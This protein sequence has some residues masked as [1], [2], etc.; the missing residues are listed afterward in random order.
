MSVQKSQ[1]EA[2]S[3]SDGWNHAESPFHAGEQQVQERLGVRDKIETFA[4]RAVRDYMPDQ[5]REFYAK[6]PFVLVGTVDDRG[7]PWASLVAKRPGFMTSPDARHLEIAARPL[8][9]DPLNGTLKPGADVGLLGIDPENRRRNR[10]TGRIDTVGPDGFAVAIG[11]AF[12]NC[13]QYIQTRAIEVLPEAKMGAGDPPLSWSDRFDDRTRALIENADT[14]FI[15]TAYSESR[16][17]TSLGAD[18]SHRG[19]KPGFV[20]LE[21]DRSFVFPDFSG[22]NHFNTTGNIV[23]NPKAGFLFVDF[24]MRDLVYTT[25]AADIVWEGEE[26][27]AFAGAERLI[28]FRAEEVIRV[29]GSLPLRFDFGEY[30]PMLEHTG[31]WPQTAETIAAEKERNVYIPFEVFDVKPESEAI[32]SFYLRRADGMALAGYEPGQFLPTRL[33]IPGEEAPAMRTYTLSDAPNGEHYRL[34]IKR[35]GGDAVVSNFLHDHAKP[36]FRLEAMAP[37]G[38]FVLGR[39]SERPV[40]LI[41][42]GVGIT[43][44]IAMANFIVNEG[45]R[46]RDFRRTYF[47]HGARDGQAHAFGEH[48]R[49]L[50][51]KHDS[52]TAHLRF[53]HPSEGDRLGETHDSEGYVDIELL[54]SMLPLGDY[55]FYLCGPPPFMRAIYDGLIG[56]GVRD[57]QIRYESFGPATV[58]KHGPGSQPLTSAGDPVDRPVAV[59]FAA[60]GTETSWTPDKGT[61][62][63]LAEAAGLTPPFAC[64][65]GIC[66]T[67]ATRVKS[68]TVD[69]VE[70]PSAPHGDN[71][72]LICCATPRSATGEASCGEDRGVVLDL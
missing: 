49:E 36:G 18:V 66:G 72:V 48:I 21:D 1:T 30:S 63:E 70:E 32:T 4:R 12:G 2:R 68:G 53:S 6:L 9:G 23:L 65:S 35:E 57:E 43:P 51:A 14:L 50:A 38:K 64:R 44:M 47:I 24:A 17:S 11:Q 8:F 62:L 15:A 26:V 56:L 33:A 39:S 42:G 25:G 69:Y 45:L 27:R 41:S 55:E 34:S 58:L 60:S 71:E 10:L 29:E 40:V 22:N 20:R 31:S 59:T 46:T 3:V 19:G 61:L 54:K 7:R 52:L 67:C 16:N 37:R 5:H 28:R 13:P